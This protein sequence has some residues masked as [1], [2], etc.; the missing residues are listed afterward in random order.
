MKAG[1]VPKLVAGVNFLSL[2]VGALLALGGNF[3]G[4]QVIQRHNLEAWRRA[5]RYDFQRAALEVR[6]SLYR[7][8]SEVVSSVGDVRALVSHITDLG[9]ML[10]PEGQQSPDLPRGE[11]LQLTSQI[12]QARTLLAGLN[13]NALSTMEMCML[14][15]DEEVQDAVGELLV[16]RDDWWMADDSLHVRAVQ[17]I[18]AQLQRDSQSLRETWETQ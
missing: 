8:M 18:Y 6:M 3:I 1:S 9:E 15:F 14:Y 4:M 2:F 7:D 16:L 13:S 17:A 12:Y 10:T 5:N 11:A